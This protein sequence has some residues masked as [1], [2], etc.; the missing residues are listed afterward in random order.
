MLRRIAIEARLQLR[1]VPTSA[2]IAR[3]FVGATLSAWGC[4]HAVDL[5]TLLV[6][7]VVTNAVLHAR[8][9]FELH[10]E[11]GQHLIRIEVSDGSTL[12]PTI[13]EHDDDDAM[14][15][16]GLALVDQLASSWGVTPHDGGKTV[17]FEVAA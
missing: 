4:D 16:R 17:W 6:S 7:E 12:T 5:V 2:G 15:G 8:S 10:V 11:S 3:R 9:D 1:P 13:R 14:T